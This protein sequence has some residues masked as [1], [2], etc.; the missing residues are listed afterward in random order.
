MGLYD[1]YQL[2]YSTK[3]AEFPGSIIP[4]LRDAKAK[5][6]E[7]YTKA[8]DLTTGIQEG[9]RVAP[10]LPQDEGQWRQS[11][12]EANTE[13]NKWKEQ[14][15]LED[16]VPALSRL[17]SNVGTKVKYL[18][19][20]KV[21]RDKSLAELDDDKKFGSMSQA[22]KSMIQEKADKVYT[23]AKFDEYGRP[24]NSYELPKK[25]VKQVN[26][27]EK[28]LT[29]FKLLHTNSDDKIEASDLLG[30][31]YAVT[32][33][34]GRTEL[35]KD[36]ILNMLAPAIASDPEWQESLV[37]EAETK[38]YYD[39]QVKG[40][41]DETVSKFVEQN[42]DSPLAQSVLHK[43]QTEGKKPLEALEEVK[44]NEHLGSVYNILQNYAKEGAF[45]Q[46][47]SSISK[48]PSTAMKLKMQEEAA[49]RTAERTAASKEG[50]NPYSADD[51]PGPTVDMDN[52][53]GEELKQ[54]EDNAK[55]A[56]AQAKVLQTQA[57]NPK[58]KADADAAVAKSEG[59]LK[60]ATGLRNE[61]KTVRQDQYET[62]T[63]LLLGKDKT[64]ES[65]KA[66]DVEAKKAQLEDVYNPSN[67]KIGTDIH[68][69]KELNSLPP[70]QKA[71]LL[72]AISEGQQG[73]PFS[74]KE[75]KPIVAPD[76]MSVPLSRLKS[77][78]STKEKTRYEVNVN[79]TTVPV[80]VSSTLAREMNMIAKQKETPDYRKVVNHVD[81]MKA[82]AVQ[83]TEHLLNDSHE[84]T[85]ELKLNIR[86][87][88]KN[89]KGNMYDM[90]GK[91]L[92]LDETSDIDWDKAETVSYL[93]EQDMAKVHL[94][95]GNRDVLVDLSRTPDVRKH[96]A[97]DLKRNP[98]PQ[99]KLV[100][101]M[102]APGPNE[103][104]PPIFPAYIRELKSS[105]GFI[106]V[107]RMAGDNKDYALRRNTDGTFSLCEGTTVNGKFQYEGIKKDRNGNSYTGWGLNKAIT[108][109]YTARQHA[110][111][112]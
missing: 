6:D 35:T 104:L 37:Q 64:W 2:Q 106:P 18:A 107:P 48:E 102:L 5:Q 58:N 60:V 29:A 55:L 53:G 95:D 101:E 50:V 103:D 61:F 34:E 88:A 21:K 65:V 89:S 84:S 51:A 40:Q 93:P 11:Y 1:N 49:A 62:Q 23:G 72:K 33:K 13:I 98:D 27:I 12:N 14:G 63:P 16:A 111:Q 94:A 59:A 28:I 30:N 78:L 109:L 44:T 99:K 26:N 79:G 82:P 70:V 15:N 108:H 85:K 77:A 90:Y 71:A 80:V 97:W 57:T 36:Q 92:D 56:L 10:V 31:T 9:L 19:E 87:I 105:A 47:S 7:K 39:P 68:N 4:D 74:E 41:T 112:E 81:K 8:E 32:T 110:Q 100:G 54:S 24:M 52:K 96:I 46:T 67:S 76:L 25:P 20:Q 3:T 66:A 69:K 86:D 73:I 43:V 75:D 45:S 22:T 42:P 91:P 83:L 38:A 17:A